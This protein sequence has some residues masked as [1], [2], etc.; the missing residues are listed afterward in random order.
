MRENV[1]AGKT[2]RSNEA[3]TAGGRRNGSAPENETAGN[4]IGA[5]VATVVHSNGTVAV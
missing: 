1:A 3:E 2:A 5:E 4:G